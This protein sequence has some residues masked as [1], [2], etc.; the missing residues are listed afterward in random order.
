MR[1]ISLALIL[2]FSLS[3]LKAQQDSVA[4]K[5]KLKEFVVT[6]SRFPASI[7][8]IPSQLELRNKSELEAMPLFN[9][10]DAL[11]LIPGVF[12]NRSWGIFSR[13]SAVTMRG[14][15]GSSRVLVM[16]NGVPL[17]QSS[18]GS[19]NW[20]LLFPDE[21]EKVEV[22][23]GPASSV[24]G[25]NAMGGV[26]NLLTKTD[27]AKLISANLGLGSMGMY[28]GRFRFQG[29][30]LKKGKGLFYN[31]TAFYRKG[32]GYILESES[33]R[34]ST[35]TKA[36]LKEY[37]VEGSLGYRFS[38]KHKLIVSYRYFDDRRGEGIK[39]YEDDGTYNRFETHFLNVSYLNDLSLGTIDLKAF[40]NREIFFKQNESVNQSGVYRLYDTHTISSDMGIWFSFKPHLLNDIFT[41][42][43][44]VKSGSQDS[45]DQYLTSTDLISN[46]GTLLFYSGFI[47]VDYPLVKNKLFASGGLRID[48]ARFKDGQFFIENASVISSASI[49]FQGY[50]PENSWT[51]FS[52]KFGLRYRLSENHSVFASAATGF[53]PP[54][55]DDMV[56]TGKIRKGMKLANP[57]LKP[58][59]IT[60]FELGSASFIGKKIILK[61]S[62]Y[63][64]YGKDFQYQVSTGDSA[65]VGESTLKPVLKRQNISNV[66]ILGFEI[67]T[68]YHIFKQ[69]QLNLS[70]N[71]NTSKITEYEK[72]PSDSLDLSGKKLMEVPDHQFTAELVFSKGK[73]NGSVSYQYI[74]KQWFDDGNTI[75]L[76]AI[77][78]LNTNIRYK[79]N[80]FF[81]ATFSVEN[82][83][84]K[85][86]I[87]RKGYPSPGRFF[88]FSLNWSM[89]Y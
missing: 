88:Q 34:D 76:E 13:N 10:D 59:S 24:Y 48:Y 29:N 61:P 3:H 18:G 39:V 58:E 25:N 40:L 85:K 17:N 49:P 32:D 44:D 60:T 56:R 63:I 22:L 38:E 65:D 87:D 19:V 78:L 55:L 15:N 42:G 16:L 20:H 31:L 47:H 67:G 69:L 66:R 77:S 12:V 73:L 57:S 11:R 50:F 86:Y 75:E 35:S 30:Q 51:Q 84:D 21:L 64:S 27:T 82:V 80:P 14:L 2:L 1:R 9:V 53:M 68:Q 8:K 70:Y 54:R 74:G 72:G 5:L 33:T 43:F 81:V 46:K 71:F 23:K 41:V 6:S 45:Y 37:A 28:S 7:D 52:P 4:W 89:Q 83:F 62:L 36:F 79:L 26:I